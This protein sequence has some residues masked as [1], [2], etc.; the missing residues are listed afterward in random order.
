MVTSFR[1]FMEQRK[2]SFSQSFSCACCC[3][4]CNGAVCSTRIRSCTRNGNL[5]RVDGSNLD[6]RHIV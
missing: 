2:N 5:R 3:S 1:H 6:G 4:N